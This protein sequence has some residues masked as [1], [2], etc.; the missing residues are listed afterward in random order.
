MRIVLLGP[1]GS[2]KGTQA[3]RLSA[4]TGAHHIC[5]GDL[6]REEISAGTPLGREIRHYN[7]RGELVPDDVIVALVRPI[8]QATHDWILDGFPRDLEQAHALDALLRE[9]GL[10]LDRVVALEVPD[11][12]LIERLAGRR[13]SEST[14]ANYHLLYHPPPPTDPGPFV[15]RVDDTPDKIRHRLTIYH[16]VTEPLKQYYEQRGLL[17]HVDAGG[18]IAEVTDALLAVL[19]VKVPQPAPNSPAS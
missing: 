6:V 18:S 8:L 13:R 12:V 19:N 3:E 16:A 7:D 1:Q 4:L 11:A 9:E 14:G 10:T 2:G 5:I 15:Q 17:V